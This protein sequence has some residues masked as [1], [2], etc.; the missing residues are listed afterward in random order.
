M[1][2]RERVLTAINHKERECVGLTAIPKPDRA[3]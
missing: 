2:H 3:G 1:T